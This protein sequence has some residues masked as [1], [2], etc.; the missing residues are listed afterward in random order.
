MVGRKPSLPPATVIDAILNFKDRVVHIDE[1]DEK[2]K[3][4]YFI[5]TKHTTY[6]YAK[7]IY[8]LKSA[9]LHILNT[10][11]VHIQRS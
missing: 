4:L 3:Y 9:N 10:A 11:S 6:I 1:N 5:T 8:I 7:T 2:S